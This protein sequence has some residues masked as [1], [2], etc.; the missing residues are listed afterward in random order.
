MATPVMSPFRVR[1][2]VRVQAKVGVKVDG[3]AACDDPSL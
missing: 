3:C 1:V 2:R